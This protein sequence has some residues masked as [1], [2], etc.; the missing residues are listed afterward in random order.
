MERCKEAWAEPKRR[1]ADRE[2]ASERRAARRMGAT[3]SLEYFVEFVQA[4]QVGGLTQAQKEKLQGIAK[5][6]AS[7]ELPE[8]ALRP[9]IPYGRYLK[10]DHW[11]AVAAAAKRRAGYRCSLCNAS[12]QLDAHHRTYE[13]LGNEKVGDVICLCRKCHAKH[14]EKDEA[15]SLEFLSTGSD[16]EWK[17]FMK[18]MKRD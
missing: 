9:V 15:S 5:R 4:L 13:N 2:T 8:S 7:G 11:K 3:A 10:T 18:A 12:G 14:H 17:V 1:V 6:L 16:D